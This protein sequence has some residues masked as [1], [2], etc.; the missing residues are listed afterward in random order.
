MR[1][2][3]QSSYSKASLPL[4]NH[5]SSGSTLKGK[6]YHGTVNPLPTVHV[7]RPTVSSTKQQ[8]Q[9]Q[10]LHQYGSLSQGSLITQK[11]AQPGYP[12]RANLQGL[13]SCGGSLAQ[14]SR[15][16][17]LPLHGPSIQKNGPPRLV[18]P[19]QGSAPDH[20]QVGVNRWCLQ[21][22]TGAPTAPSVTLTAHRSS[23][24]P[25]QPTGATAPPSHRSLPARPP[26]PLGPQRRTP[27]AAEEE[28]DVMRRKREYWRMKKKEQRARKAARE[29]GL[30]H[31]DSSA[32]WEPVL[33][34]HT[35]NQ[36]PSPH[37]E[38]SQV[39]CC[40]P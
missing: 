14:P 7:M 27:S 2:P 16:G 38:Q 26:G 29:R 30:L 19:Q 5:S 4:S 39:G 17:V 36:N 21:G 8:Q 13:P 18:E 22:Q 12:P 33:P 25:C 28:D 24:R 15:S 32:E 23:Q 9:Q 11:S 6:T 20:R 10:N 35:H 40:K 31:L 1:R 3:C 34:A 37:N